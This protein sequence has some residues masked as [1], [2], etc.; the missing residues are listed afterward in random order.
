M[1]K[2]KKTRVRSLNPTQAAILAPIRNAAFN[3]GEARG[4][5]I[6]RV[7]Q[8]CGKRPALAL[9]S[10]VKL[11]L[12]IGFMASALARGGDN[13]NDVALFKHCE[14]RLTIYQGHGGTGKLREGMK[15]R[16][17]KEEELAYGSA[18]VLSS[19]IFKEAGV[20]NPERRG[21]DTSKT[22]NARPTKGK[23]EAKPNPNRVPVMPKV[24]TP[25]AA[26]DG[27]LRYAA[28]LLAY[29]NKNAAV[30]SNPAKS[31]VEAFVKATKAL[32]T[33]K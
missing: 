25:E 16:R 3:A 31:A 21:G 22:R 6:R 32:P 10:A 24:K 13:R 7:Q 2:A 15:G 11:Q 12:Q 14:E 20:A 4:N 27:L 28:A 26:N 9:Y 33:G 23:A 1:A 30:M 19:A 5:V 17:T 8:G 29:T 18:R